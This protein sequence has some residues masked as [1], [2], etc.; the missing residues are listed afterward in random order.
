[1]DKIA[2]DNTELLMREYVSLLSNLNHMAWDMATKGSTEGSKL[3]TQFDQMFDRC[4][5]VRATLALARKEQLEPV[6]AKLML[7]NHHKEEA[8]SAIYNHLRKLL[9]STIADNLEF[10]VIDHYSL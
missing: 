10:A 2:L 6:I 7:Q 9:R 4:S 3:V 1:M 8:R 5:T